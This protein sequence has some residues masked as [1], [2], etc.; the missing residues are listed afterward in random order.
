MK[1]V[2][3][4]LLVAIMMMVVFVS[5]AFATDGES[6]AGTSALDVFI[7][8]A[9]LALIVEKIGEVIKAGLSP[10]KLPTWG[11]FIIAS[12]LGVG[13]CIIFQVDIFIALGLSTLTPASYIAGQIVTGVAV[14][15][16]SNFTH[17]LIDKLKSTKLT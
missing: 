5:V 14:G 15:G 9:L 8:V 12:G 6:V 11:W 3:F 2:L 4:I 17:D 16:G 7:T 10:Y 1:K 13:L